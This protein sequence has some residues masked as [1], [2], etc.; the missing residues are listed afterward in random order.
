MDASESVAPGL[1]RD[2]EPSRK[3]PRRRRRP[4]HDSTRMKICRRGTLYQVVHARRP[5]K[6]RRPTFNFPPLTERALPTSNLYLLHG[7]LH[8]ESVFLESEK[9]SSYA[10]APGMNYSGNFGCNHG[11]ERGGSSAP[12]YIYGV[13]SG[14]R[15]FMQEA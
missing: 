5:V 2:E 10:N 12:G 3:L 14:M 9:K 15:H 4:R 6:K 7:L 13:L 1:T 11:S 8:K